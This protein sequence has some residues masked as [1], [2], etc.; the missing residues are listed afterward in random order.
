MTS[1]SNSHDD[2]PATAGRRSRFGRAAVA[3][4]LAAGVALL[5]A[6]AVPASAATAATPAAAVTPPASSASG[7]L[8]GSASEAGTA[9]RR[10]VAYW[11]RARMLSAANGASVS[12]KSA[13]D[14]HAAPAV[15]P[16]PT[17][18]VGGTAPDQ[19]LRGPAV[20]VPATGR[21]VRPAYGSIGSPWPGSANLPPATTTGRVFFT[22]R[23]G[24]NWSCSGSTV[25][26]AGKDSVIT[27]GHCVYG[28][29]GGQVSG[30]GWHTNWIFV[31][32]Y[33]NGYAPYGVW[34]AR[35]LWTP[36]NYYDNQDEGDDMGGAVINT[37]AYGQHIVNV[38]GGQGIA[39]NYPNDQF[40]YNFGYPAEAPFNGAT[41]EYCTGSE[42]NWSGIANTMG[43][44]CNFTGGS[45]GG[46][47]LMSFNGEFGYVNGVNDFDY[48]S[49][50]GYIFAAYFGNNA[51]SLYDAMA[52]L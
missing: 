50:P 17:G 18:R 2:K 34:T 27:A 13:S 30:E 6:A 42:F 7:H 23:G 32:G 35:E 26:S 48:S 22:T 43:L 19:A 16:G 4:G 8:T 33:E 40:V 28:S 12:V 10:T 51:A 3:T 45:S 20:L 15:V 25:N 24:E 14:S 44:P 5:C 37:N 21:E 1:E 36:T 9:A 31:P 52:N 47:W 38:V 49:L 11:T 46:P 41:L 39:W 29:L